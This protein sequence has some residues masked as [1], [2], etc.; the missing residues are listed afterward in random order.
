MVGNFQFYKHTVKTNAP[1][2]VN[3]TGQEYQGS[4]RGKT[5]IL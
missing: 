3:S 5:I 4:Y 1:G 2:D